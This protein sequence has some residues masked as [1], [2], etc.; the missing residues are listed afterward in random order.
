MCRA[1]DSA[2]ARYSIRPS[3]VKRSWSAPG[4]GAGP[5]KGPFRTIVQ[6]TWLRWYPNAELVR[7]SD[8]G[9]YAP[10]ETP[11]ALVSAIERFLAA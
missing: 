6:S 5:S 9:H 3:P 2:S 7:F 1:G 4:G 10:D 8:A 11:L